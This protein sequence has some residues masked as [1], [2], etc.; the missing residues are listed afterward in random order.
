MSKAFV[1]MPFDDDFDGVFS[2]LIQ[3][4]LEEVGFEVQRADLSINQQQILKDIVNGLAEADLVVVDVSGL[5]GN[6][7]YELGL[8]HAMGRRTVMITRDINEL[9]FDLRSYRANAYSTHFND[10]PLL[11]A[12]LAEIAQGVIDGTAEFSNPVQ[13]FAPEF[14]GRPEQLLETPAR[15][16]DPE[17][18]EALEEE[19]EETLGLLDYVIQMAESS[20]EVTEVTAAISDATKEVGGKI[21]VRSEQLTRTTKN[22]G[23]KAAPV[24]RDQMR[25]TA[26]DFDA[27]SDVVETQNP[28]L[29]KALKGVAAGANGIARTRTGA[30]AEERER[31]VGEIESLRAAE[32]AFEEAFES[33]KSFASTI[34]GLPDME[35][36][37]SAAVRRS[38]KAVYET[39]DAI[40]VGKSEIS[41]ARGVLEERL[42]QHR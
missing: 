5:N 16:V 11:K 22:L 26:G 35:K 8:A 6:V 20:D 31:I 2:G 4:A 41:R 3:P 13:D 15:V 40:E 14:L 34:D 9:P 42:G 24:L 18:L 19:P 27:F 23:A 32:V 12:K 10:A 29:H 33:I 30:N 17:A 39:A 7:M 28:R 37:L 38:S 25:S 21:A 36:S 1:L